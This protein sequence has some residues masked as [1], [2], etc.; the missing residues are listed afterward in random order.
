VEARAFPLP[1]TLDDEPGAPGPD[2]PGH[3][4]SARL[5]VGIADRLRITL[6]ATTE[7]SRLL[8]ER[9]TPELASDLVAAGAKVEAIRVDLVPR[10]NP[11]GRADAA[12]GPSPGPGQ[13][14]G[15]PWDR[16]ARPE[17]AA[18]PEPAAPAAARTV[19]QARPAA[20]DGGKVDRY[21]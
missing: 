4:Q 16:G 11:D 13:G 18:A 6:A 21:A 2:A 1:E 3:V 5:S 10:V 12:G 15:A 7:A 14:G 19:G 8:L 20:S 9:E 17:R